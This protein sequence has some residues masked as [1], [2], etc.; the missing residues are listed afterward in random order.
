ME[1]LTPTWTRVPRGR[2]GSGLAMP[3]LLPCPGASVVCAK[4]VPI[5]TASAP[6]ANDL[7]RSPPVRI[8]P[9]VTMGTYL[10]DRR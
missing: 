7:Q 3:Q 8:P 10:P 9:S 1:P 6:A 5:M 2:M 4:G